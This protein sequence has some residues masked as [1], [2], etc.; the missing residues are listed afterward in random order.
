MDFNKS[1]KQTTKIS[2]CLNMLKSTTNKS[3]ESTQSTYNHNNYKF[4][5]ENT[6]LHY[7]RS[8]DN[9]TSRYKIVKN[10]KSTN[11]KCVLIIEDNKSVKY[12]CKMTIINRNVYDT[13][14]EKNICKLLFNTHHINI[15]N[16]IDFYE[17]DQFIYFVT[18]FVDGM[19]LSK[20]ISY[21]NITSSKIKNI[22][23]QVLNGLK[24][25]HDK[26]IMHCDIKTDNIMI[27]K[28]E[29]AVIIDFDLSRISKKGEIIT[30]SV[31]G[32]KHFIAPESY[33]LYLYSFKS[34]IW[35]LGVVLHLIMNKNYPIKDHYTMVKTRCNITLR[36]NM[37][38]HLDILKCKNENYQHLNILMKKMLEFNLDER[39]SVNKLLIF[40][41]KIKQ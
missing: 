31:F 30:D 41:Q 24:F 35:S 26:D 17:C 36:R 11:S 39:P 14:N 12:I 13:N 18:E 40:I 7:L 21:N 15:S 2:L 10:L 33:D 34:D 37:F 32:T 38:K 8:D 20:Y 27:D 25:L 6:I 5:G 29:R 19:T 28:K 3:Y 9:F 22:T 1:K 16:Y 23:L 4:Y